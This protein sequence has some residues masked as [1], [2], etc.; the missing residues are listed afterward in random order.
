MP[1]ASVVIVWCRCHA[2][3]C[4]GYGFVTCID[5][6]SADEGRKKLVAARLNLH[7][8]EAN[9]SWADKEEEATRVWGSL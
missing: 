8:R 2:G 9:I 7:G 1:G 4:R 3:K 5:Q 6:A